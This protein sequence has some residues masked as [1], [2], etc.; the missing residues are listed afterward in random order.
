MI[1]ERNLLI[2]TKV[3]IYLSRRVTWHWA[4]HRVWLFL[5][6]NVLSYWEQTSD[7]DG[8]AFLCAS[9]HKAS[10]AWICRSEVVVF[11]PVGIN[12][13]NDVVNRQLNRFN[14][15]QFVSYETWQVITFETWQ[16]I[17]RKLK[18][19]NGEAVCEV[20]LAPKHILP[21]LILLIPVHR[22]ITIF[23]IVVE[24]VWA[25]WFNEQLLS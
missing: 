14:S 12:I 5:K 21:D 22:P 15:S 9:H 6:T 7:M 3:F 16:F 17:R 2:L 25:Q 10:S 8:V 4:K 23:V 13:A 24:H 19:F 20:T 11:S 1:C 18:L